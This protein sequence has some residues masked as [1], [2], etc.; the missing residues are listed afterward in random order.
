MSDSMP[1]LRACKPIHALKPESYLERYES[2]FESRRSSVEALF[3][4]GVHEGGSLVMWKDY[5]PNALVVGLD[6]ETLFTSN[7][8]RLKTYIG[9]QDDGALLQRICAECAPSGFDIIIDDC[10]HIGILTKAS[11]WPLFDNCLKKGGIYAIE[12]WGTGYWDKWPDGRRFESAGD[13]VKQFDDSTG[14]THEFHSHQIG[15]PGF[16][17]QLID[18]CAV[19]DITMPGWS[20]AQYASTHSPILRID[21]YRGQVFVF[22]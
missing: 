20:R 11:F 2:Y 10:S 6:A 12:D 17:K 3:E 22:K 14:V 16:I 9:S 4:L 8:A 18:E 15:V 13:I 21:V 1:S 7:D 5:F 19:E